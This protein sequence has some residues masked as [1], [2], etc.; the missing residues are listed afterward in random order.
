MD[1]RNDLYASLAP[2]VH[3]L[4]RAGCWLAAL[5]VVMAL[6]GGLFTLAALAHAALTWLVTGEW[7]A[8]PF[9]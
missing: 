7:P 6:A 9:R 1:K 5:C 2:V 8:G 4:E 3:L